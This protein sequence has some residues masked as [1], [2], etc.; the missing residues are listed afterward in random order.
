MFVMLMLECERRKPYFSNDVTQRFDLTLSPQF[1][2]R[3]FHFCTVSL[4]KVRFGWR[5]AEH[6]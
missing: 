5:V 1:D 4:T 6:E 3:F 2:A